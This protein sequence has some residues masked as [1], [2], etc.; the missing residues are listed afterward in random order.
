MLF[1]ER[2]IIGSSALI[3]CSAHAGDYKPARISSAQFAGVG[4]DA[5]GSSEPCG[6]SSVCTTISNEYEGYFVAPNSRVWPVKCYEVLRKRQ[7]C[8]DKE[9]IGAVEF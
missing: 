4:R 7:R 3:L 8:Q 2:R 6:G 1:A 9:V 5:E